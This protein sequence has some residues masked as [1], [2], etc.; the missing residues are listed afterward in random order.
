MSDDRAAARRWQTG[1][2]L[3]VAAL[4]DAGATRVVVREAR[5]AHATIPILVRSAR[6]EDEEML[7]RS[8]ATTVM[9]PERAGAELLL[10]ASARVLAAPVAPTEA[11]RVVVTHDVER[12]C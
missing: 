4:P 8:G 10:D 12:H 1:T 6:A 9:T 11:S 5:R 7:T 2:G 3:V